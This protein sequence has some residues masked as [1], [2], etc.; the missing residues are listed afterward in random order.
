VVEQLIDLHAGSVR[1]RFD[2]FEGFAN[3]LDTELLPVV[4]PPQD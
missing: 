3:I 4:Q 2:S 1:Y